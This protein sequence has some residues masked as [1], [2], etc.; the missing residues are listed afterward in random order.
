MTATPAI[1][2]E[3]DG[4]GRPSASAPARP[5]FRYPPGLGGPENRHDRQDGP[6]LPRSPRLAQHPQE[7]EATPDLP[8]PA[9]PVRGR[10]ARRRRAAERRAAAA[11][12]D[13]LRLAAAGTP[14]PVPRLPPPHLRA[15]RAAVAGDPR[16][17][18]ARHVPPGPRGRRPG[19]VGF[20]VHE[21]P[22]R[23]R[24]RPAVRPPGVPLRADVLELGI[25]HGLRVGVVRGPV[26]RVAG[27]VVG[28]GRGAPAAPQ[29]QLECGR[30]QPVG[31]AGVPDPLPRPAD[32]LRPV[33][34]AD[35]RP[36][37]PRERGR[38]VVA[39][40]LQGGRRSG[41]AAAGEPRVR[42]P[43]RVRGLPPAGRGDAERGPRR[44]VR[45]GGAGVAVPARAA[46]VVVPEGAVPGRHRQP[47]PRPPQRL[48]GPQPADRRVRRGPPVR[49]PG[50]GVVRGPAR[51]HAAAAGRPRPARGPLP[52]RH[53]FARAEAG[54]VRQLRL[55]R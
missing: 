25:G 40:A 5:C 9:R 16:F 38:G 46:A 31:D 42:R 49:R 19:R 1:W 17:G 13:P 14:G 24:G 26:G 4:Y 12:Q 50:R 33:G 45:R 3:C 21:R 43:G 54:G 55:P 22:E 29:R 8:H 11:G 20:H 52:A 37:G 10:L 30:E 6:T 18:Q 36:A 15:P 51:R 48:L 7:G 39:R 28:T 44:P 2:G 23:H 34:P 41:V 47:D 32:A 35:Q 53:R 27:R